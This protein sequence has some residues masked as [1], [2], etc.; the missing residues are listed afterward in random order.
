MLL[1]QKCYSP[2]FLYILKYFDTSLE[3][4]A[5]AHLLVDLG[6]LN[7]F[8]TMYY[9][10]IYFFAYLLDSHRH[11]IKQRNIKCRCKI[12][13]FKKKKSQHDLIASIQHG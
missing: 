8:Y 10:V 5:S 12:I 13:P 4:N 6:V 9:I 11:G 1:C 3:V 7:V 2:E